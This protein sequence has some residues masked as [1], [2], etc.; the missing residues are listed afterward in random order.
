M[1][2]ALSHALAL[3]GAPDIFAIAGDTDGDAT[4]RRMRPAPSSHPDTLARARDKN[5]DARRALD[6]HDSFPFFQALG[7]LLLTGPTLTNVN[8][9]RLLV[10]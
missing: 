9:L 4:E 8:A 1:A 6:T 10:R 2:S 3:D 7:D 5:L